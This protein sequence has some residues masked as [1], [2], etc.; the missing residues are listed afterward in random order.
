[1]YPNHAKAGSILEPDK[2]Q[3][4]VLMPGL[5]ISQSVSKSSEVFGH[6]DENS[7]KADFS[8]S[9]GQNWTSSV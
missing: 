8:D 6:L 4:V 5:R 2:A 9:N 3:S 7:G 1:M